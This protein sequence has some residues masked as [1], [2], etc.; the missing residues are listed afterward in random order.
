MEKE[1]DEN[2][3]II[4]FYQNFEERNSVLMAEIVDYE[5]LEGDGRQ[6]AVY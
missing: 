6:F 5:I 2:S 1:S 4:D 3:E